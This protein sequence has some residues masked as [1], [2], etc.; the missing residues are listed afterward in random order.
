[1]ENYHLVIICSMDRC[2]EAV[3]HGPKVNL[4]PWRIFPQHLNCASDIAKGGA[5]SVMDTTLS[6]LGEKEGNMLLQTDKKKEILSEKSEKQFLNCLCWHVKPSEKSLQTNE[7]LCN[8]VKRNYIPETK[9]WQVILG[10]LQILRLLSSFLLLPPPLLHSNP[11]SK[12]S[13][14]SLKH[15]ITLWEKKKERHVSG[16][17][18]TIMQIRREM[19]LLLMLEK[20]CIR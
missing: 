3:S 7:P 17:I 11:L 4:K 6:R 19:K 5:E 16:F 9:W 20:C 18:W 1:M 8:F 2:L 15:I 12:A 13:H 10:P 14:S